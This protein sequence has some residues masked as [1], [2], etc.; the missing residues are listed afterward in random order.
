[1]YAFAYAQRQVDY[2]KRKKNE[3]ITFQRLLIQLSAEAGQRLR[4]DQRLC[5]G[6]IFL[7]LKLPKE[8]FLFF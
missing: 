3:E 5:V 8:V 1:M 6:H 2:L 7:I 4:F